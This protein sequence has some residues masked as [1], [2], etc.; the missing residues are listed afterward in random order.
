MVQNKT[1]KRL[2]MLAVA[3]VLAAPVQA[4]NGPIPVQLNMT[5]NK[6]KK[7]ISS[8]YG[9]T[10]EY[11]IN[12]SLHIVVNNV[13]ARPLAGVKVRWG[14]VQHS[15]YSSKQMVTYGTEETIDI[16]PLKEKIIE[17]QPIETRGTEYEFLGKRGESIMAYGA[18]VLIDG[19]VVAQRIVPANYNIDF[20]KLTPPE[21]ESPSKRR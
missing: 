9:N 5:L 10:A 8:G 16:P 7:Q 18:Q 15:S 21:S 19:K 13:S 20:D 3:V 6:K 17:T 14:M 4:Q 2:I 11:F 12:S 1:M